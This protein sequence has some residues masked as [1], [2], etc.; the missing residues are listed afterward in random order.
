MGVQLS[1]LIYQGKTIKVPKKPL[2]SLLTIIGYPFTFALSVYSFFQVGFNLEDFN[3]KTNK[4]K[5]Y[6]GP[7]IPCDIKETYKKNKYLA[8]KYTDIMIRENEKIDKVYHKLYDTSKKK[9]DLSDAYLQGIY[10]IE[11]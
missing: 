1:H 3:S 9:D 8:I 7:K 2:P 5:A 6:E 10:W 4:L 11:K